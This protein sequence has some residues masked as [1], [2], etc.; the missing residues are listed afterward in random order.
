MSAYDHCLAETGTTAV[1]GKHLGQRVRA[2]TSR[3][4]DPGRGRPKAWQE[5]LEYGHGHARAPGARLKHGREDR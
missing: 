1:I 3:T 4:S 5:S 2:E